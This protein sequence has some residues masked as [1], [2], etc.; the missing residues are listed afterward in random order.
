M[1]NS[2]SEKSHLQ[3]KSNLLLLRARIFLLILFASFFS[4]LLYIVPPAWNKIKQGIVT[5]SVHLLCA[6]VKF[7]ERHKQ[8]ILSWPHLSA[9]TS[10]KHSKFV[11]CI[12]LNL[13]ICHNKGSELIT[14]VPICMLG[15]VLHL[16]AI[17]D[18]Q[19]VPRFQSTA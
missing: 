3:H 15:F 13:T 4:F 11:F 2:S 9:F 16:E 6:H 17:L 18:V 14:C 10:S 8:E 7:K 12:R 5:K 1:R 19:E